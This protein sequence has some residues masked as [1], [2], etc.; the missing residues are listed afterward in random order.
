MTP[1]VH[2]T[3]RKQGI[4]TSRCAA[5]PLERQTNKMQSAFE[6]AGMNKAR[7]ADGTLLSLGKQTNKTKSAP[8]S[9][10]RHSQATS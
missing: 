5:V 7:P 2:N 9:R 3:E 6:L 10:H 4:A 1:F 8:K